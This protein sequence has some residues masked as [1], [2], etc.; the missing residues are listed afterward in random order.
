MSQN[1]NHTKRY[2]IDDHSAIEDSDGKWV[3]HS[4][5]AALVQQG[6][7]DHQDWR[8]KLNFLEADYKAEIARLRAEKEAET[9]A[10]FDAIRTITELR[11]ENERLRK[12]G[13]AMAD[14]FKFIGGGTVERWHKAKGVQS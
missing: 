3:L 5:H 12:A 14:E 13:D 10:T 4:D 2:W 6:I 9:R 1:A 7:R 8:S 11:D